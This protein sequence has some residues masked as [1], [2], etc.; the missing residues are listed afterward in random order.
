MNTEECSPERQKLVRH[1]VELR[2]RLL[3]IQ[4]VP[5]DVKFGSLAKV[6]LI[7]YDIWYVTHSFLSL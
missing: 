3:E 1:L 6:F 7:K 5:D 4:D 2:Y